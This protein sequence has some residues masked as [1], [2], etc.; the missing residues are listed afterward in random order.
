VRVEARCSVLGVSGAYVGRV[1]SHH[2]NE[3]GPREVQP[4]DACRA[5]WCMQWLATGLCV[6]LL[7]LL[8]KLHCCY[9]LL[10][11]LGLLGTPYSNSAIVDAQGVRGEGGQVRRHNRDGCMSILARWCNRRVVGW[12]RR[13]MAGE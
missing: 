3:E 12:V 8:T 6:A 4:Q 7:G 5:Q 11:P 1:Y 10:S 13:T 9:R 2:H